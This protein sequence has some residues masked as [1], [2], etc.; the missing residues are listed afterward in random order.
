MANKVKVSAEFSYQG[1]VYAL[2]V[3]LDLDDFDAVDNIHDLILIKLAKAHQIDTYSYQF[4]V[5][6]QSAL[7]F[8]QAEGLVADYIDNDCLDYAAFKKAQKEALIFKKIAKIAKI[9]LDINDL[10][11]H[12]KL[13]Q[14]L[15]ECYLLD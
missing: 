6:Q 9:H 3:N 1:Q 12:P 5:L 13:K 15:I 2:T 7:K 14:A 8:E 11:T 4:E 10:N